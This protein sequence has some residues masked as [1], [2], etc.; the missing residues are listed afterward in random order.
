MPSGDYLVWIDLEMTGLKPATDAIIEIATVVTDR[1][2]NLIADGPVLAIHQPE[3]VLARMDDWNRRQHGSSGLL[4]RV[5]A[6][7]TRVGEAQQR[8]LGFL[9]PLVPAGTWRQRTSTDRSASCVTI[10]RACLPRPGREAP[11]PEAA[12]LVTHR[13]GC[14][15]GA[16]AFEVDAPARVTV[17]E[18]NC[19]MCRMSGYLHLIVPRARFRLLR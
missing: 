16:I 2:L 1:D 8:T 5:R 10:A 18:C 3:E 6:S 12:A 15:C 13:G 4:A 11:V 19:S 14:H 9:A 7:R 17:S